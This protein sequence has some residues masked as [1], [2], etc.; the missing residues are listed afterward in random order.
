MTLTPA[1]AFTAGREVLIR[2]YRDDS[3]DTQTINFLLT[4]LFFEFNDA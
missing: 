2:Y 4:E 3:V 1:S